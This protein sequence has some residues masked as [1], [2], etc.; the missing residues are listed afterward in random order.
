[1]S[2]LRIQGN[3]SALQSYIPT[4]I[5]CLRS[6]PSTDN[7][8]GSRPVGMKRNELTLKQFIRRPLSHMWCACREA[9]YAAFRCF[10]FKAA[11]G[12]ALCGYGGHRE[13]GWLRVSPDGNSQAISPLGIRVM[14]RLI[15]G[16][17]GKHGCDCTGEIKRMNHWAIQE[18]R[19][20]KLSIPVC[21]WRVDG[22]YVPLNTFTGAA[23][24]LWLTCVSLNLAS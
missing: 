14:I 18:D 13:E 12:P 17:L 1:V 6:V 10:A 24:R 19:T 22:N 9:F 2:E 23:I 11:R 20:R 15:G 3:L 4:L 21:V 8:V 5:G 7:V 16:S